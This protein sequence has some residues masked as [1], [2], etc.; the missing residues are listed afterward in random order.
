MLL[1]YK[2]LSVPVI[3]RVLRFF[4][5]SPSAKELETIEHGSQ[6]YSKE[7][8]G[9]RSFVADADA[10]QKLASDAVREAA[11]KWASEPYQLLEQKRLDQTNRFGE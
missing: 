4:K 9:S 8:S 2:Q 5:V 1:N 6:M 11:V 3:S 10:K 7:A